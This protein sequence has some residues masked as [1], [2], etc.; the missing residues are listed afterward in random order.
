[1]MLRC[2][3]GDFSTHGHLYD[4]SRFRAHSYRVE[5][6]F[7]VGPVFLRPALASHDC[8]TATRV[9]YCYVR[10]LERCEQ[11]NTRSVQRAPP[12]DT[13]R[14]F[15]HYFCSAWPNIANVIV[16]S[17]G[18]VKHNRAHHAIRR[19]SHLGTRCLDC[20]QFH[21]PAHPHRG[22]GGVGCQSALSSLTWVFSVITQMFR[23]TLH[24]ISD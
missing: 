14:H 7:L 22:R 18:C 4:E 3:K 21:F 17:L 16:N 20:D 2:L 6:L 19:C 1:M 8:F 13:S 15:E 12:Q 11:P 10:G 9:M 23:I 5:I 24:V